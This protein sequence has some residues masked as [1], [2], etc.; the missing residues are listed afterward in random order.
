LT[1]YTNDQKLYVL[2]DNADVLEKYDTAIRLL[3][4]FFRIEETVTTENNFQAM[5]PAIMWKAE[6]K[7]HT[8]ILKFWSL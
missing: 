5:L 7:E 1:E 6:G 2:K 8:V 4:D 3:Q